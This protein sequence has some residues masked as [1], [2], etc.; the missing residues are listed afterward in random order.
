MAALSYDEYRL[1]KETSLKRKK[2]PRRP[3]PKPKPRPAAVPA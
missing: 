1:L 3:K 2:K